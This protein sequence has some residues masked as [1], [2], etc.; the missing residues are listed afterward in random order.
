MILFP[1]SLHTM[2]KGIQIGARGKVL[3]K[4]SRSR[5]LFNLYMR[6]KILMTCIFPLE[7]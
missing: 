4:I 2:N 5:S 6:K 3:G 7:C 1:S